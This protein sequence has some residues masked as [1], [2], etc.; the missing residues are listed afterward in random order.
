MADSD[1]RTRSKKT[2][3]QR[4]EPFYESLPATYDH[5]MQAFPAAEEEAQEA[6][7]DHELLTG[8]Q[9]PGTDP[10][11]QKF[12]AIITILLVAFVAIMLGVLFLRGL[13]TIKSSVPG[14]SAAGGA[15][16]LK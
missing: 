3:K 10:A 8:E 11:D 5:F 1:R 2:E 12:T 16:N 14:R 15:I 4:D 9:Q 7:R 13:D 6:D